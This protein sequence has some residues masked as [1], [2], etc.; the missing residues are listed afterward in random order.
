MD[1]FENSLSSFHHEVGSDYFHSLAKK[2]GIR[3]NVGLDSISN[4]GVSYY[5]RASHLNHS[6]IIAYILELRENGYILTKMS[7]PTAHHVLM[8]IKKMF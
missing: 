7:R 2:Y 3:L 5:I 1:C 4:D 6:K 8:N